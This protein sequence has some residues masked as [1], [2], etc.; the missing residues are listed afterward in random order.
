[1]PVKIS[2]FRL[3]ADWKTPLRE[4]CVIYAHMK[5]RGSFPLGIPR[6]CDG[7]HVVVPCTPCTTITHT[8]LHT[9][10]HTHI[11]SFHAH[12]ICAY[13]LC[14]APPPLSLGAAM[15]SMWDQQHG[16]S[17]RLS[18]VEAALANQQVCVCVHYVCVRVQ[19]C[20]ITC[21]CVCLFV[22]GWECI[23]QFVRTLATRGERN[24]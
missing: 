21:M 15:D 13:A 4:V 22:S 5:A 3:S 2:L 23:V 10:I 17:S 8:L 24:S 19:L 9:H 16:M 18:S 6:S 11:Q 20:V 7:W 14:T 1:M 12:D